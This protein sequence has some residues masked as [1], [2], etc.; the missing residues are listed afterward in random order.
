MPTGA[1]ATKPGL[2]TGIVEALAR[3]MDASV[4]VIDAEPGTRV[5]IIHKDPELLGQGS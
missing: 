2:G 1:A 4:A 5:S 3:Q